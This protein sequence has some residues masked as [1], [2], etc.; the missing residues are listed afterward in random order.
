MLLNNF[1]RKKFDFLSRVYF[2]KPAVPQL[3]KKF[4]TFYGHQKFIKAVRRFHQQS[5]SLA[6]SVQ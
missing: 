1:N 3:F 6:K 2:K 4:S 5:L